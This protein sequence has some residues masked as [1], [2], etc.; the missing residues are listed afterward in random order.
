MRF[1]HP[2]FEP[3]VSWE[4]RPAIIKSYF[5]RGAA[6]LGVSVDEFIA[7]DDDRWVA[8]QVHKGKQPLILLL[9]AVLT[10]IMLAWLISDDPFVV[11]ATG[12]V[13][14]IMAPVVYT[15]G[16]KMQDSERLARWWHAWGARRR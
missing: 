5:E 6:R 4:D 7:I 13:I 14:G 12:W 1:R 10:G 15:L 9:L 2:D 8:E 11:F 16:N 3:L